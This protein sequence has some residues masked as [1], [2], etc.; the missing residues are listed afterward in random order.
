MVLYIFQMSQRKTWDK[1][2]MREA[3]LAVKRK[4]MGL[5]KASQT[6]YVP[7]STIKDYVKK[8]EE[9]LEKVA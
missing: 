9:E 5:L 4:E 6:I 3:V 8:T 7:R 1:V 2:Q